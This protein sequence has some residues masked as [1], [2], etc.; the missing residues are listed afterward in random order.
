MDF[1]SLLH[2][3]SETLHDALPGVLG[4]IVFFIGGW[5]F[6]LLIRRIVHG[7]MKK[8]EWD[9]KLLGNTIVD[10]NKFIANLVYYIL[11]VIVLLIVLEMLGVSYVLDPIK[12]ML[13]EF[14]SYIDNV[15]AALV[16]T[17]IGYILAKFASNLVRMT[18][19]FLDRLMES[20]GFNDTEKFVHFIQQ[21]VFLLVFIP[22][23]ILALN[24]LDL[25]AITTPANNMLHKIMDAVP[26]IIGAALII[27]LFYILGRFVTNFVKDLLT[28]LGADDW[29]K[30]LNLFFISDEQSFSTVV[31]NV[32][33]FFIIFTGVVTGSD[34]LGFE[35]MSEVLHSILNLTGSILFG[36]VVMVIGNII[37]TAIHKSMSKK[38]EDAFA[39]SAVKMLIIGLFFAISLRTMGIANS[40]VELAF[41]LTLGSLAVTIALAYGLGGREAAG[42]H[43]KQIL[44][45]FR[46]SDKK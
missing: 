19:S 37:A 25:D 35:R 2:R 22:V 43:M 15:F 3:I 23:I 5:L 27:A 8:T 30:K 4:A 44:N 20:V 32:L 7:L 18:G 11:M 38:S 6:S 9:E 16:I 29:S 14:L 36:L 40:I 39:A 28:N 21:L 31:S 24:A 1:T 10:T 17:F 45:K 46:G 26:H 41:G 13:D 12:N 34:M 33:F 42:E